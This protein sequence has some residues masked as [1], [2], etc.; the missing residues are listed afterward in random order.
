MSW[1]PSFSAASLSTEIPTLDKGMYAARIANASIQ[2]KEGKSYFNIQKARNWNRNEKVFEDVL[3]E[4]GTQKYEL[5]CRILIQAVL[6]SKAAIERL[7]RDEPSFLRWIDIRFTDDFQ[8]DTA[9]NLQ[10]AKLMETVKLDAKEFLQYVDASNLSKDVPE[11][12]AHQA[13]AE[14]MVQA[15]EYWKQYFNLVCQALVGQNVKA[16]IEKRM[17]PDGTAENIIIESRNVCGFMP[18]VDGCEDDLV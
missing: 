2:G 14:D 7:G 16:V 3:N 10:F 4:D 9:R 11:E 6:T 17:K 13:N 12:I 8:L 15:L 5:N 1:T 18:Y